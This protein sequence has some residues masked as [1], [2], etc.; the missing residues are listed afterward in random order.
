MSFLF[1]AQQ[2]PDG[3][4]LMTYADKEYN[5]KDWDDVRRTFAE[6][7]KGEPDGQNQREEN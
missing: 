4:Y 1:E 6:L 7:T 5:C 3:S 2:Q